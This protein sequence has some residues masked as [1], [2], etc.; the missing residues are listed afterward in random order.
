MLLRLAMDGDESDDAIVRANFIAM[1]SRF[2]CH[3]A[4][5]S[6]YCAEA[7]RGGNVMYKGKKVIDVHGHISTPPHFR[8][9]AMNLIALRTAA[10][11]AAMPEAA[12]KQALDRH[13][14]ML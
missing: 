5:R 12:V 3:C 11:G 14:R 13:L 10:E 1:V 9:A 8:A 2:S 4:A 7:K 6:R